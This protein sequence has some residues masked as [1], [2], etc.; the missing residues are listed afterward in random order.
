MKCSSL[1]EVRANID[2]IDDKIIQ[3]ITERGR[4]VIQASAFKKNADDVKAPD[5]VEEVIGKVRKKAIGYGADPD[6]LETIYRDM[7]SGF[8]KMELEELDKVNE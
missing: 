2:Q 5:R 6:M 1:E 7:I 3:L 8:I 4:Y